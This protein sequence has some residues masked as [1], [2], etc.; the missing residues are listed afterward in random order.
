MG[1][2]VTRKRGNG[3]TAYRAQII[4]KKEGEVVWQ[5]SKTF[6]SRQYA[7]AWLERREKELERGAGPASD[8]LLRE[9]IDKSLRETT[10][11]IGKTKAQVLRS[12]KK[13]DIAGQRCS[14]IGSE[15]YVAFLQALPVGPATRMSYLSHLAGVVA[16]ARPAWGYPLDQQAVKDAFIVARRLGLIGKGKSRDRR[17]TIEELDRLIEHFSAIKKG[18][19]ASLP[20]HKIIPFAIFS[21]R[22]QEEITQILR[23]DF[24]EATPDHPARIL[25][26][27]MKHPGDKDGNNVWC[28]LGPEAVAYIKSMPKVKPQIFP[29]NPESISAAFTRACQFLE[30]EDLHFHDLR[31]DGVSRL[32]EM[33]KTIPQVASTSGHRS[34]QNLKRYTHLRQTGDKYANWKWRTP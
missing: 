9:V 5:E 11:A 23:A 14:R 6:E 27:D 25:V 28:D 18:R 13:Y 12:I 19:P 24:E 7:K 10:K 17:P 16:I 26:R 21:T 31:H 15:D 33:G 32:F 20:M 30:I 22:R 29:F 2:I 34:W 1:T 3:S 4:L 8:P